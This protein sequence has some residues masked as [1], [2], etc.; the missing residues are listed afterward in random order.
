MGSVALLKG[1]LIVLFVGLPLF[2][3]LQCALDYDMPG[4]SKVIWIVLMM[5]TGALGALLFAIMGTRSASFRTFAFSGIVGLMIAIPAVM[6]QGFAFVENTAASHVDDIYTRWGNTYM[7]DISVEQ[8]NRVF[9]A[10]AVL[11]TETQQTGKAVIANHLLE[12]LSIL[13]DDGDLTLSEYKEWDQHFSRRHQLAP[14]QAREFLATL[15]SD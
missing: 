8:H 14:A 4:S 7:P 2:G 1:V 5:F 9:G 6:R 10:I 12:S 15:R 3:I 13:I 11:E